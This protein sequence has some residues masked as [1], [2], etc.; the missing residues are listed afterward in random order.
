MIES[1]LVDDGFGILVPPSV[2]SNI[3]LGFVMHYF[4]TSS[5]KA[6]LYW[7][8]SVQRIGIASDVTESVNILSTVSWVEVEIGA[9][10]FNDCAGQSKTVTCISAERRLENITIDGGS[11]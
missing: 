4:D 5:K 11:Y 7:D 2:D 1:G 6:A 10:W 8:D 9:L 3:D